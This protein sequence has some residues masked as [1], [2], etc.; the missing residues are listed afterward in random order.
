MTGVIKVNGH[1]PSELLSSGEIGFMFQEP[2]LFPQLTV[3]ENIRLPLEL[4]NVDISY[5][6][7][8]LEI[9]GL[10]DHRKRLPRELSGGMKTRVALART[11]APKPRLLLLDE[12]FSA[13]DVGWRFELYRELQSLQR[14]SPAITVLVTHD[15]Q[16]ALL[17]SNRIVVLNRTGQVVRDMA[18]HSSLPRGSF[19][20]PIGG[21]ECEFRELHNFFINEKSHLGV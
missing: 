20:D 8:L 1:S 18:I 11:L 13:L 15:I 4:R 9:V 6:D 21:R 16:E 3:E 7:Y 10:A 2:S 19:E 14:E 17:L 5:A 12:P